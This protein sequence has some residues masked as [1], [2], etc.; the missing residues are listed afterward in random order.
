MDPD[1][2]IINQNTRIEKIK[3]FFLKNI[4][5]ILIILLSL[6]LIVFG[7]FLLLDI[8][9]KSKAKIAEDY[10]HIVS[11][12][13]KDKTKDFQNQLIEIIN[14]KDPTYSILA[15]YFLLDNKIIDDKKKINELFDVL[16]EKTEIDKEIK[17]LVIYKKAL[18]NSDS[19]NENQLLNLLKPIINSESVWKG[20]SLYL[21]AEFFYA[22]NEK[23]KS[24]EFFNQI[25]NLKEVNSNLKLEA[26]KKLNRDF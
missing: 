21:L 11:K 9:K 24:K 8:K 25:I 1:I 17:N 12:Y 3:N 22:K 18:F 13:E 7:Y 23:T 10:N 26:Q 19:I 16:I 6:I 14:K 15:L 5:K 2:E 4:K 20:H